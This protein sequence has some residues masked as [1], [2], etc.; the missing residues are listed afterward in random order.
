MN[1]L[2][3]PR[4]RY[5]FGTVVVNDDA[6]QVLLRE[7]TNHHN[8]YVWTFAKGMPNPGETPEETA[9][10]ESREEYGW[11]VSI[12]KPIPHW[13]AGPLWANFFFLAHGVSQR[14]EGTCWETAS[15]SWFSWTAAKEALA[16]TLKPHRRERDFEILEAAQLMVEG[17]PLCSERSLP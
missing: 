7:P 12:T 13:F 2:M 11:D 15:V 9:L 17:K 6:N 8:G 16:L 10:R 4:P 3:P 1:P 5:S 14:P